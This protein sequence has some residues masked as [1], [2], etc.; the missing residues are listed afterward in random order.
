MV[1]LNMNNDTPEHLAC[2][3]DFNQ[4]GV[5]DSEDIDILKAGYGDPCSIKNSCRSDLNGDY[6]VDNYDLQII[7]TLLNKQCLHR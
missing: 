2:S 4:N 5:V 3:A 7:I 6:A 1:S